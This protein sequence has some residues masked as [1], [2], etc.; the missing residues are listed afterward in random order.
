MASI[1][2]EHVVPIYSVDEHR[3]LPYFVMEYVPGGT[4]EHRLAAEGPMST[5]PWLRVAIQIA[6]GLE[7]AHRQG[8]IHRDIKPSNI[9]LDRGVERVRVYRLR[10]GAG[11]RSSW[12][13]LLDVLLGTPMYMSPEQVLGQPCDAR[14]DLFSLGSLLY[15]LA[16][17]HPPFQGDSVYGTLR[18]IASEPPA[19]YAGSQPLPD[20]MRD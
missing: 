19:H 1:S 7:A 5:L 13:D 10:L 11:A 20:W 17:G 15:Q 8:L 14:S 2:H 16:T 6:Q 9:L 4:L 18:S 3:S 12:R